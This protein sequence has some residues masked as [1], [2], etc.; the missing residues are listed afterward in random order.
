MYNEGVFKTKKLTVAKKKSKKTSSHGLRPE[1]KNIVIA[2]VFIVLWAISVFNELDSTAGYY[3]YKFLTFLFGEYYKLIFSPVIL[4]LWVLVFVKEWFGFNNSR[5]L[6]LIL[7]FAS[8][9]TIIGA[10]NPNYYSVFNFHT[11]LSTFFGPNASLVFMVMLFLFSLFLMFRISYKQLIK[12][13]ISYTPDLATIKDNISLP[14]S[15]DEDHEEYIPKRAQAKKELKEIEKMKKELED[16]LK[17]AKKSQKETRQLELEDAPRKIAIEQK[18]S[19]P[20]GIFWKMK[21]A[22][23]SQDDDQEETPTQK[24]KIEKWFKEPKYDSWEFPDISLLSNIG[25]DIKVNENDIFNKQEEIVDKLAQFRINVNMT[26]YRVGPTVIQFRL[27]PEEWV[28]L[29]KIENLKKDLTLA[30]HAKSIRIQAPIPG[31]W[32]VGIEV[33]NENRQAVGLREL[34]ASREFKNPKLEIPIAVGK[35]VNGDMIVWDL[36]KMPHLLVAGQTASWKSVGMNGFIISML[37]TFTPSELKMIMIDPKRVE[38]SIYNGIPH[39]LTPVITNPDKAVNSLKWA[40]AEMMRR[41]DLATWVNARNFKEYNEKVKKDERLPY[42]VIVV[43]ELADLMMSGNKKEVENSIARIAQMARAVGMHLI[44]ATQRPSVDVITGLIKA[45][46]PS[47]IA[48]TVASQ[49]DSRTVIDKAWAEDLLWR[50]D[51]LYA[52]T[53]IL[54]PM[55]VQ[56]VLVETHEVESVVNQLKLT[57]D[58]DMINNLYD[59]SIVN[60]KSNTAGSIL[61]NYNG[62]QEEEPEIIEKAIAIVRESKKWSTSLIQRKLWLGY[63]RAAKVLDILEELWVVGPANGS[64]PREVYD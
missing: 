48:F 61:E 30:L 2:C 42:I 33:P 46:I 7:Y 63:A 52:P 23:I 25:W 37:Y 24:I 14:N 38:L 21:E 49:I 35:D 11:S 36:T 22:L 56:W 44:V 55:R 34:I 47:R 17:K 19:K 51:M 9:N 64:K 18:A 29:N 31:E 3:T 13:V 12:K 26:G 10:F 5:L 20:T 62:E 54:E 57:V 43:D 4:A 41:Y 8:F 45:N 15:K 1:T 58:P 27:K 32:V 16:E 50:W 40:V 60:G 28:K 6:G 53:G 39:L 59:D